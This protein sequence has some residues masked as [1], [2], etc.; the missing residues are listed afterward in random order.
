MSNLTTSDECLS[1]YFKSIKGIKLLTRE[2]EE[3]LSIKIAHGDQAARKRLIEA[4]L[5][6]V[7]RIARSMWNPSLTLTDLIQEGNIGLMKA[8]EKF[9][10]ARKVKF[11]TYAAWWIR[12]SISRSLVNTGRAIRLPHRKEELIRKVQAEKSIMSQAL[13]RQPSSKEISAKLGIPE[14]KLNEVLVFSERVASLESQVDED[15]IDLLDMYEDFTYAPE[16][17]FGEHIAREQTVQLLSVLQ[18]RERNVIN[19]RF[20]I[21]GRSRRSLKQ[22]GLEMRLS[23][24][25]VRHIEKRAL[26]KLQTEAAKGYLCLT[27]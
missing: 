10:G 1:S 24:E 16:K 26:K 18:D 6:L 17:L 25:T 7:V 2:E 27:A 3:S 5:R 20:E 21:D 13:N 23:P 9:D 19:Q 8:A 12:Q 4:N 14:K 11:S 15:T 22:M